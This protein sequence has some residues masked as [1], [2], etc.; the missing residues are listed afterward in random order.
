MMRIHLEQYRV[1]RLAN[2]DILLEHVIQ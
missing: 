1:K 2:V